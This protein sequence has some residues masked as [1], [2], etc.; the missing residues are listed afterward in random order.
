MKIRVNGNGRTEGPTHWVGPSRNCRL[1]AAAG[2][3]DILGN[4]RKLLTQLI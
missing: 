4:L 2:G 3:E 1:V